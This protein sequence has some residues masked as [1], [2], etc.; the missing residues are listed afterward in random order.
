MDEIKR[1]GPLE[2]RLWVQ[3]NSKHVITPTIISMLAE[4]DDLRARLAAL[5][6]AIGNPDSLRAWAKIEGG[7]GHSAVAAYLRRIAAAAVT[8]PNNTPPP[9][10]P[11]CGSD[12]DPERTMGGHWTCYDPWHQ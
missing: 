6:D 7:R 1:H 4:N 10:C 5:T 2:A 3:H 8:T 12:E 9:T 11:Q